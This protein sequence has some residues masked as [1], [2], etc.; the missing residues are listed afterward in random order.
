MAS[1]SKADYE[2][3]LSAATGTPVMLTDDDYQRLLKGQKLSAASLEA[4]KTRGMGVEDLGGDQTPNTYDAKKAAAAKAQALGY[5]PAALGGGKPEDLGG[6]TGPAT[7]AQKM[8][9]AKKSQ[10]MGFAPA[11]KGGGYSAP[12]TGPEAPSSSA[13]GKLST[14]AGPSDSDYAP[15][16]KV[17]PYEDLSDYGKPATPVQSAPAYAGFE[18][19]GG[20]QG[21]A[22]AA[23]GMTKQPDSPDLF[24]AGPGST[25]HAARPGLYASAFGSPDTTKGPVYGALND[26]YAALRMAADI[27]GRPANR[28]RWD[29]AEGRWVPELEDRGLRQNKTASTDRRKG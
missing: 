27:G 8:A 13:I 20:F 24:A 22:Y 18:D 6:D 5:K 23:S 21:R 25:T 28:A 3:A 9:D 12:V 17:Q 10:A 19:E 4:A 1:L 29:E 14:Y 16:M 11:A 7:P 2:Q 15:S 26:P